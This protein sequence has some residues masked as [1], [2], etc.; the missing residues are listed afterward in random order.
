MLTRPGRDFLFSRN[1][2]DHHGS[3]IPL[4]FESRTFGITPLFSIETEKISASGL[5]S[6]CGA[7]PVARKLGRTEWRGEGEIMSRCHFVWPLIALIGV[8]SGCDCRRKQVCVNQQPYGCNRFSEFPQ[9]PRQ[10]SAYVT[11]PPRGAI[12]VPPDRA[13]YAPPPTNAYRYSP[14]AAAQAPAPAPGPTV[15]Q[16]AATFTPPSANDSPP[17]PPASVRQPANPQV[18]EPPPG[19]PETRQP[20]PAATPLDNN[21]QPPPASIPS[22]DAEDLPKSSAPSANGSTGEPPVSNSDDGSKDQTRKE[23]PVASVPGKSDPTKSPDGDTPLAIDLPGYTVAMTGVATGLKPFPDGISWLSSKGYKT[24]MQL[25]SAGEDTS[26]TQK[27]FEQKGLTFTSLEASPARLSKETYQQFVRVVKDS[28]RHPLFVFDKDG[29]AIG[30]LWY[31]YNRVE[32]GKS[33][34][35]ARSEAE[36]VGLRNDDSEHKAM[37]LAVQKLL[38]T[39]K[40]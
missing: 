29:S 36:R 9:P 18:A 37:W 25:K 21:R 19:P 16:G 38:P 17:P 2:D 15:E 30:G 27:L 3:L 8:A 31:L 6:I 40:P 23:P 33:D 24:A 5:K 32:L 1:P 4:A 7:G 11:Q 35:A 14:P 39:L 34:E 13:G 26:A 22:A 10:N 28:S 20:P 12:I